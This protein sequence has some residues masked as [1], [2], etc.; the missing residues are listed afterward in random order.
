MGGGTVEHS[1]P[2][3]YKIGG[4]ETRD[5]SELKALVGSAKNLNSGRY[6]TFES[7]RGTDYVVPAGKT[8]YITRVMGGH[9]LTGG[10]AADLGIGYGDT[11]VGDDPSAPTNAKMLWQVTFFTVNGLNV[12]V[13]VFLPV[14]AGKY[15]F[16][17]ATGAGWGLSVF[18]IEV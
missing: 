12:D 11:G 1:F 17:L 16:A 13:E 5:P 10:S 14:P 6:D 2:R 9:Q 4:A 8:L 15:P 3:Y 7:P 18:G